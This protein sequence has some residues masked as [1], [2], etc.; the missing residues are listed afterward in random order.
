M[1][2]AERLLLAFSEEATETATTGSGRDVLADLEREFPEL[3]QLVRERRV[4]DFGCGT[5]EQ[6]EAIAR[7]GAAR[8]V[9]IDSNPRVL[10][11][12]RLRTRNDPALGNLS[13]RDRLDADD[14][15]SFDVVISKDAMEHFAE[16]EAALQQ[17]AAALD[18]NGRVLVTFGPPWFAP[19]GSHMHFFTRVPWLNLLFSEETVMSV[20]SRFRSDGA[21]RYE[22]VESGLNRMTVRRFERIVERCSLRAAWRRYHC[23]RRMDVLARV[24]GLRELLINHVSCTLVKQHE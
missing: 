21:R 8:V 11:E 17:M 13:F 7:A 16:P 22:E 3:L 9:G 19:Y 24:P 4:L 6:A 15:G 1:R 20:R 10:E 14:R 2:L 18:A 5:G 23:V 12:A